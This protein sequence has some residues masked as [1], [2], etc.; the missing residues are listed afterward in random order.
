[1]RGMG[2]T[3]NSRRSTQAE[4]TA[5]ILQQAA[6]SGLRVLIPGALE[7]R[8][9][10]PTARPGGVTG[11]SLTPEALSTAVG[12]QERLAHEREG[13]GAP[14]ERTGS[15]PRT[16]IARLWHCVLHPSDLAMIWRHPLPEEK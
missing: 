4:N 13:G 9:G 6:Q 5:A 3:V 15:R 10:R 2:G 12:D 1:M 7:M 11:E 14:S 16:I 8:V